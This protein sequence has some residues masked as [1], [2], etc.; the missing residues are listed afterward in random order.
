[1]SETYTQEE[2]LEKA[3]WEGG[4]DAAFEYGLTETDIDR[5]EYPLFHELV[6]VAKNRYK[7]YKTAE[8]ALEDYAGE[9]EE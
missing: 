2:W 9:G 5:Q 3:E 7:I 8:Y 1:M 6:R 4:I